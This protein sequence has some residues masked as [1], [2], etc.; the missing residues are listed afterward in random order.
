MVEKIRAIDEYAKTGDTAEQDAVRAGAMSI[1]RAS[2]A[3]QEKR[4]RSLA[5]DQVESSRPP[6]GPGRPRADCAA[7]AEVRLPNTDGIVK[8]KVGLE[9]GSW[10]RGVATVAL[11]LYR[12]A[13]DQEIGFLEMSTAQARRLVEQLTRSIGLSEEDPPKR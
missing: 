13:D 11:Y 4:R 2:Q 3:V 9:V 12:A 1:N 7:T 5:Q 6:V 8:A 10:P